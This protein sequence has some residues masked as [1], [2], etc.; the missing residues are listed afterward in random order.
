MFIGNKMAV[1]LNRIQQQQK[2][3]P[4]LKPLQ[5]IVSS[6]LDI[7]EQEVT[8]PKEFMNDLGADSL[9]LVEIVM[10]VEEHFE[11]SIAEEDLEGIVTVGDMVGYLDENVDPDRQQGD[12]GWQPLIL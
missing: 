9:D 5:S 10:S 1:T 11:L 2:Q 3:S 12:Q 4:H 6:Q 7:E 8:P